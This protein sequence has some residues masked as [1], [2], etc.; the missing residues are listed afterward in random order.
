MTSGIVKHDSGVT[1][2]VAQGLGY[3][4]EPVDNSPQ[5]TGWL[6]QGLLQGSEVVSLSAIKKIPK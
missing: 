3:P 5:A 2:A 4:N 1:T 6:S